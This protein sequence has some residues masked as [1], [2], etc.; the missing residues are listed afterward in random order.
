MKICFNCEQHDETLHPHPNDLL[1]CNDCEKLLDEPD[2]S[3]Q[4]TC[5]N[6]N[7]EGPIEVGCPQCPGFWFQV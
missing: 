7:D 4:G 3:R 2:A 5:L 6:C 1:I